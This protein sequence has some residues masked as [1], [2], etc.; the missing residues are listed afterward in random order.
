MKTRASTETALAS[1]TTDV[2]PAAVLRS[3]LA[4]DPTLCDVLSG[5]VTRLPTA[6]AELR[7]LCDAG[8]ASELSRAAHKLRGA[9]GSFGLPAI[10]VA[11]ARLEDCLT[12]REINA[13][14]VDRVAA[15]VSVLRRVEGY[16]NAAEVSATTDRPIAA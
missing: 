12:A 7:I 5:F 11:A 10:S 6:A 16:D 14:V 2:L 9:G 4:G 3:S 1:T 15:L 13:A 8:H